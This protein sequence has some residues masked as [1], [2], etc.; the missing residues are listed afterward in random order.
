[1]S[2]YIVQK[3]ASKCQ[4]GCLDWRTEQA[5]SAVTSCIGINELEANNSMWKRVHAGLPA[6]QLLFTLRAGG[7]LVWVPTAL[8]YY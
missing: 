1:M 3:K 6:D 7:S 2:Y 4:S 8:H 5:H